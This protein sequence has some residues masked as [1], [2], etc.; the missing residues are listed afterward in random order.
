MFKTEHKYTT[1]KAM[2]DLSGEELALLKRSLLEGDPRLEV[3][4]SIEH[5]RWADSLFGDKS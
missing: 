5:A 2:T 1:D 4:S 3:I